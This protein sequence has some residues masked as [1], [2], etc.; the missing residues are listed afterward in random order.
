MI[1]KAHA[2]CGCD[3][4]RD[5]DDVCCGDSETLTVRGHLGVVYP[6]FTGAATGELVRRREVECQRTL[7]QEHDPD[8]D[9][10]F[11]E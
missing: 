9:P 4:S 10:Y 2:E 5:P 8:V 7:A 11:W 1:D 3:G 6:P